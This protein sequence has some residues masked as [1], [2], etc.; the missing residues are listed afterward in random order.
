MHARELSL[1]SNTA[2]LAS[3]MLSNS[4]VKVFG[5]REPLDLSVLRD[6]ARRVA[7]LFPTEQSEELSESWLLRDARPVTLVAVDGNWRQGSK[8]ARKTPGLEGFERVHLPIEGKSRYRLR[9]T[10]REGGL[11]TFEAVAR[12]VGLCERD[13][14]IRARMEAVFEVM[15]ERRLFGRGLLKPSE[16]RYMEGSGSKS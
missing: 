1:T 12:A 5:T 11:S 6:S 13:P 16:L 15:V 14:S 4:E 9:H 10:D 2:R 7:V 8:M 3:R